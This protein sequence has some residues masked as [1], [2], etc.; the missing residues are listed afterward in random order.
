MNKAFIVGTGGQDGSFLADLLLS[1][2]YEV[3]GLIRQST[4]FHAIQDKYG[5]LHNALM[6]KN[7]V[8]HFGDV[9]DANRMMSLLDEIK[10]DEVY[11]LA[12][13][14]HV[15]LSFK[16]PFITANVT[17]LG[18]L[19][20][21]EAI[22]Q[23]KLSTKYYQAGSSEMFG[24]AAETPQ[25]ETTTFHPRSPYACAKVFGHHLTRNYREAHGIFACNGILFN[26]ESERRGENFVTRKV[27]KAVARISLGLQDK[28]PLGDINVSRD[29][30][31]APDY[32]EAMWLMMQQDAPDDYVIG[33]GESR[34]VE[35]FVAKAFQVVDLDYSKFVSYDPRL[36]RPAEVETLCA[37]AEKA[38]RILSWRP[39]VGFEELIEKMV[40]HDIDQALFE[41]EGNK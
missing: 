3:H 12:A 22:K 19:N 5:N 24:M 15:G 30:G 40:K 38:R 23:L 18:P 7:F 21:L 8:V 28:L 29:W 25:K 13:Q 37:D 32:V 31:Y 10:P 14:S 4:Q 34:S 41:Q 11:N 9:T 2:G 1:K 16:Q 6:S 26:H 39:K 33:T 36:K 35:E 27:T 17:A 20:L